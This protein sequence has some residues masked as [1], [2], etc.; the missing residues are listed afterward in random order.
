M[1]NDAGCQRDP[2]DGP[3]LRGVP[4]IVTV[5]DPQSPCSVTGGNGRRARMSS[6]SRW[7]ACL[8]LLASLLALPAAPATAQTMDATDY[9][10]IK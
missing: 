10:K 5:P 4:V 7:R 9:S 2:G 6:L 3:G 1:M 8:W